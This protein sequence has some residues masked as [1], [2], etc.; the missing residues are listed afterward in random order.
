LASGA[1]G[2]RF[3]SCRAH[4][5]DVSDIRVG[6]VQKNL[7]DI[8][9]EAGLVSRSDAA[10]ARRL[11]DER[12]MPLVSALVREIGA[13]E[14]TLV[15]A[16]RRILRVPLI[17]PASVR[18]DPDALR[19]VPRD[20]CRRLKVLPIALSADS[21]GVRV[22]R[23]AMADPTDGSAIAEVEHLTTC[24]LDITALPLSAIEELTE[25]GYRG[26]TTEVVL[27]ARRPFGEGVMTHTPL[28]AMLPEGGVGGDDAPEAP[29]TVPHHSVADE[30]DVALRVRALVQLL[31]G[32]G[33]LREE[34][35]DEA[36]RDLLK[37]R[38]DEPA[39]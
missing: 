32:K 5:T 31:V 1:K 10:R 28:I 7:A 6:A 21:S 25:T 3:D 24:E 16:L 9:V 20:V 15:G 29:A 27:R 39:L 23:L 14:L 12:G 38:A 36:V 13:D 11:A 17:D 30:A 22:M 2:R 33:I 19:E 18:P 37:R 26:M 4:N 34:E 35:Y 8:A